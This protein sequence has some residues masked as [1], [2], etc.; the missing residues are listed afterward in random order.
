MAV[1]HHAMIASSHVKHLY[2]WTVVSI[3]RANFHFS[4]TPKTYTVYFAM[5]LAPVYWRLLKFCQF[6]FQRD[7]VPVSIVTIMITTA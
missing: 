5:A 2:L 4:F 1:H 6:L 3:R 7:F